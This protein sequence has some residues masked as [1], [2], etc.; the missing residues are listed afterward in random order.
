MTSSSTEGV[1][2]I[3]GSSAWGAIL[4]VKQAARR[5]AVGRLIIPY[6]HIMTVHLETTT[7]CGMFKF[8]GGRGGVKTV[9]GR[10]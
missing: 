1:I 10:V 2:T 4:A 7:L 5:V 3:G 8:G 6:H 9:N